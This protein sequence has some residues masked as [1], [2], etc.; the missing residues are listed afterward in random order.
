MAFTRIEARYHLHL[1]QQV[2]GE[3]ERMAFPN[4]FSATATLRQHH[5][6]IFRPIQ[7]QVL[8]FWPGAP[9]PTSKIPDLPLPPF[10]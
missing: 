5:N 9:R 2:H 3:G 1:T 4:A 6:A 7:I 10:R 8:R